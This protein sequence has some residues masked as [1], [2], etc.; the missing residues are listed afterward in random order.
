[1]V[2]NRLCIAGEQAAHKHLEK[3]IDTK[4][5]TYAVDRNDPSKGSQSDL[6]PYLHFGQI[7]SLASSVTF[8]RRGLKIIA[9][10]TFCLLQKCQ[11]Q[12]MQKY[13]ATR[14]RFAH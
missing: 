12:K 10:Y 7:S 9:I 1:M 11:S 6:S 3:F 14:Y 8:E 4:L 13:T 5:A 2:L